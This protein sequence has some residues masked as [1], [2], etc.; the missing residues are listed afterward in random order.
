MKKQQDTIA[1]LLFKRSG[2]GFEIRKVWFEPSAP[3]GKHW[4]K[5]AILIDWEAG[6]AW[7]QVR[8]EYLCRMAGNPSGAWQRAEGVAM[9]PGG[10]PM[11][12]ALKEE[13]AALAGDAIAAAT[14]NLPD[15]I[16]L[17]AVL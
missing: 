8:I 4:G 1:A 6:Q 5:A 9:L 12:P 16:P 10:F 7:G 13:L 11:L 2:E 15:G 17:A 3:P 14:E